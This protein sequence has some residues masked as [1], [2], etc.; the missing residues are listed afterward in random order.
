MNMIQI[1]IIIAV[2]AIVM[3]GAMI[4]LFKHKKR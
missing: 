1:I 4:F 3:V 2:C